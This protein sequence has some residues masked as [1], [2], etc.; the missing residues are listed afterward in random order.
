MRKTWGLLILIFIT[1]AAIY[2]FVSRDFTPPATLV[3]TEDD[4]AYVRRYVPAVT[5]TN[6]SVDSLVE[7]GRS[8][9]SGD[10]LTT[11]TDGYAMVMFL[12]QSIA[13]VTPSSQLVIRSQ[14]NSQGDR[15]VRTHIG[16]L[17]GSM[18]FDVNTSPESEFEISTTNAVASVKGTR[19]GVTADEMIWV[20]E[21][22]VEVTVKETGE[23]RSLTERMYVQV[24]EGG[25]IQE[26][27]L[28]EEQMEEL[29]SQFKILES[30]LIEREMR[31]QFRNQQGESVEERARIFEQDQADQ[32]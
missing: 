30:D 10:T 22:E 11:S 31:I 21:G 17:L 4:I 2:F 28:S 29:A 27:E 9:V 13:R 20:E 16:M 7:V 24:E 25:L 5:I 26:G 32:Q 3:E 8:L 18:F 19:F 14:L 15:N 12:D 6:T 23:V 1:V